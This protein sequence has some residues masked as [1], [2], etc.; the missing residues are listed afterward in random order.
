LLNETGSLSIYK[1]SHL[2]QELQYDK[3]LPKLLPFLNESIVIMGLENPS[4]CRV[5]LR[6]SN[7]DSKRVNLLLG[8]QLRD[9]LT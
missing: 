5:T 6:L 3:E 8:A 2:I 9:Y 1:G 7:S 4:G